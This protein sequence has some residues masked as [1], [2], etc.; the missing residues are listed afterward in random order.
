MRM[1]V[2]MNPPSRS[3]C[4]PWQI[5]VELGVEVDEGLAQLVEATDPHLG[6]RE[7][8]HPQ[9]Q[10]GAARITVGRQAQGADVIAGGHHRLEHQRHRQLLR[11]V[12]TGDHLA[13]VLSDLI[14]GGLAVEVLAA[15]DEPDLEGRDGEGAHGGFQR[16]VTGG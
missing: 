1:R 16:G 3:P 2:C 5:A 11:R 8:V 7:G 4:A 13:R 6:R 14:E 12:E 10:T 15:D 9:H